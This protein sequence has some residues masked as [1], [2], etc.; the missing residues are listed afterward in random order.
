MCF[1]FILEQELSGSWK[2]SIPVVKH[3]WS[4]FN[5]VSQEWSILRFYSPRPHPSWMAHR[6]HSAK[7]KVSFQSDSC[8]LFE[9]KQATN[10]QIYT[11]VDSTWECRLW[12]LNNTVAH[13]TIV[14]YFYCLLSYIFIII[15]ITSPSFSLSLSTPTLSHS[16]AFFIIF[17][18][19]FFDWSP[20]GNPG[21]SDGN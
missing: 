13:L 11:A 20:E 10:T 1:S 9:G 15:I 6:I 8:G 17:R 16:S 14:P 21:R 2:H 12:A 18:R 4:P 3:Y 7:P 19:T 5:M